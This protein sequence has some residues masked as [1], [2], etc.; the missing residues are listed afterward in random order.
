MKACSVYHKFAMRSKKK[1]T[2][3]KRTFRN[4]CCDWMIPNLTDD[5]QPIISASEICSAG[6]SV[7][8]NFVCCALLYQ[9][10]NE[11]GW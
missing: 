5:K 7:L 6:V 3:K 10:Q 11:H 4:T 8:Y 2:R 1:K 9:N